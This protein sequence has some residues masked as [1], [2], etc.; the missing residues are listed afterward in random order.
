VTDREITRRGTTRYEDAARV[1]RMEGA[2]GTN[3]SRLEAVGH[4]PART[5]RRHGGRRA[6]PGAVRPADCPAHRR[7]SRARLIRFS[8]GQPYFDCVFL[9]KFELCNKNWIYESCR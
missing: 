7:R 5:P 1:P 2:K 3:G 9:Q 8:A 6:A 4:G